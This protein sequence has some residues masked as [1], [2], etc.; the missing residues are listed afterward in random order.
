[1]MTKKPDSVRKVGQPLMGSGKS[2]Y[3]TQPQLMSTPLASKITKQPTPKVRVAKN[4]QQVVT[5]SISPQS[6][7]PSRGG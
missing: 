5:M 4:S 1:M 2:N 7:Q 3:A 6:Q